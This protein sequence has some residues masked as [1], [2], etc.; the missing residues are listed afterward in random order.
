MG[1]V[2]VLPGTCI[3]RRKAEPWALAEGPLARLGS[4]LL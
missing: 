4:L 3:V 2:E 1:A